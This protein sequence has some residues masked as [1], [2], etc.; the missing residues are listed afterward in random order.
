MTMHSRPLAACAVA[1]AILLAGCSG[2]SG[3]DMPA[4]TS[5][6]ASAVI[7]TGSN[8]VLSVVVHG[9]SPAYQWYKDGAPI[10][11]ATA[12]TYTATAAGTYYVVVTD[13]NGI[14]HIVPIRG[15]VN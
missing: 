1:L 8:T 2:D 3:V 5:Q 11:D 12:A 14:R 13:P 10:A 15:G 9:V 4:I 6:P 7:A